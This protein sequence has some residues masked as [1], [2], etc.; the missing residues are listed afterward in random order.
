MI[1][2]GLLASAM[3]LGLASAAS[4][5]TI[6]NGSFEMNGGVPD[7]QF[8][9][10][11]TRNQSIAGWTVGSGSV[12]LI[13]DYWEAADGSFSLDL[14]GN[15]SGSIFT[16]I[17]DLVEGVTYRISFAISG[18]PDAGPAVKQATIAVGLSGDTVYTYDTAMEG[19]TRA[20]MKWQT[21]TF[22]FTAGSDD[23]LTL[24]FQNQTVGPFGF[25]LDNVAISAVPV[26]AAGLML[27]GALGGLGALRRRRK[28]A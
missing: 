15:A 7:G 26:P 17:A 21:A 12:D 6:S 1:K 20:D 2:Q 10:L 14:A 25:A 16:T 4:A 28:A 8:T 18:N 13:Q 3:A 11:P 24:S 27:L 23:D 19:N 22:L 5:A 9:T